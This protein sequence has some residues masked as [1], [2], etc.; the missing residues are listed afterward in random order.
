MGLMKLVIE[1]GKK[2]D[3]G[4]FGDLNEEDIDELWDDFEDEEF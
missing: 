2:M 3:C 1:Q 4:T